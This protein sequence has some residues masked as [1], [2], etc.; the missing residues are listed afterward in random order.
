MRLCA[1]A[2]LGGVDRWHRSDLIAG[3]RIDNSIL[4]RIPQS[5]STARTAQFPSCKHEMIDLKSGIDLY[6]ICD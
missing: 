4:D 3:N 2:K 5:R 1:Q 6:M